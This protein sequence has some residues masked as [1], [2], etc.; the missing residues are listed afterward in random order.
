MLKCVRP[1]LESKHSSYKPSPSTSTWNLPRE[2]SGGVRGTFS[3]PSFHHPSACILLN[4]TVFWK[5]SCV[6]SRLFFTIK[7]F[8]LSSSEVWLILLSWVYPKKENSMNV[9]CHGNW[10]ISLW[11]GATDIIQLCFIA[12]AGS[13]TLVVVVV[14][15]VVVSH[16]DALCS[17]AP[18]TS[19]SF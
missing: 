12:L 19:Q 17:T 11:D 16:I 10:H 18:V 2:K 5:V 14:V 7:L 3:H 15:V 9:W 13:N 1:K 6:N 4:A 8:D